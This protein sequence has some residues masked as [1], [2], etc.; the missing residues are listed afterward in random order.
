MP[1]FIR[2]T[3]ACLP[4]KVLTND[5]LSRRVDTNDEWIRTR[6]GIRERRIASE[7]EASSDL[8][9]HASLRALE[10]ARLGPETIDLILVATI[11][12]DTPFPATACYLQQRLDCRPIPALDLNAACSGFPYGL[13][14]ARQCLSG[15]PHC[16][17]ILLVCGDKMSSVTDWQDRSSCVLLGDGAGAVIVGRPEDSAED[18]HPENS[19]GKSSSEG[20]RLRI[21]DVLLGADG[22]GADLI[23]MPAGG[24]RRPASPQT[25][26][27]REHFFRMDGRRVFRESV[28]VMGECA[29][30]ILR[31]NGLSAGE[32]DH[33]IPHQANIRIIDA[34]A[35]RLQIPPD[36]VAITLDRYGNTS[37]AT[38][39]IALDEA[40]RAGR[41]ARGEKLLTL[42]F[43]AGLT[44]GA[45]LLQSE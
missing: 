31:R 29:E 40:L 24:S 32:I 36:R 10:A 34:V 41:I 3:G 43:G 35:Q 27:Q 37:G 39:P 20:L 33:L 30:E 16:R 22:R 8:C 25:L 28:Q 2:G 14:L 5:E 7:E 11:T 4:G 1:I 42:A 45:A 38:I 13:H 9:Y 12:P 26:E 15:D 19:A 21:I 23:L 18:G 44:W 17:H 6:T